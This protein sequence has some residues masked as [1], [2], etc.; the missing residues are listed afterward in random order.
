MTSATSLPKRGEV[1]QED[2][3]DLETIYPTDADWERDFAAVTAQLPAL[4]RFQGHVGENAQTLL[5]T[6]RARDDTARML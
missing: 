3:W 1:R 2:T 6:L 4:A 5:E